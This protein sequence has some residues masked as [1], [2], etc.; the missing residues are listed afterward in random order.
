MGEHFTQV[1]CSLSSWSS[2]FA[3]SISLSSKPHQNLSQNLN[4]NSG[5]I[6]H[7]INRFTGHQV[8]MV[9]NGEENGEGQAGLGRSYGGP[10]KVESKKHMAIDKQNLYTPCLPKIS[11]EFMIIEI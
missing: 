11:E 7:T 5:D 3:S 9:K 4:L 10:V 2:V 6:P 1:T 8:V